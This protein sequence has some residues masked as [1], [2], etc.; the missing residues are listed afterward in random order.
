MEKT[1]KCPFCGEKIS[2]ITRKCK[3]CCGRIDD[4]PTPQRQLPIQSYAPIVTTSPNQ[5]SPPISNSYSAQ[6]LRRNQFRIIEIFFGCLLY[7]IGGW[8]FIA[9]F[10]DR[11][12]EALGLP[13]NFY[14]RE[15]RGDLLELIGNFLVDDRP[16]FFIGKHSVLVKINEGY[17]GFICVDLFFDSPVIQWIMLVIAFFLIVNAFWN[18]IFNFD[19]SLNIKTK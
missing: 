3:H 17:H 9:N 14:L 4:R 7:Y 2:S 12:V 8:H 18:L 6:R 19:K 13:S 16:A 15:W 10:S 1:R 5:T 11:T